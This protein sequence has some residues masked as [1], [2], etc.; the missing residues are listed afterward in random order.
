MKH[1]RKM[2]NQTQKHPII[3]SISPC[4]PT[5]LSYCSCQ[6]EQ[7]YKTMN[8]GAGLGNSVMLLSAA[9]IKGYRSLRAREDP[10]RC[11]RPALLPTPDLR[12]RAQQRQS[13]ALRHSFHGWVTHVPPKAME[14]QLSFLRMLTVFPH[15]L[16]S[17][18]LPGRQVLNRNHIAHSTPCEAITKTNMKT[19]QYN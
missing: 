15:C 13:L 6:Q 9:E 3:D 8:G 7:Y 5:V 12:H 4:I 2:I 16:L 18:H 1:S 11:H 17:P 19:W 10:T 14:L